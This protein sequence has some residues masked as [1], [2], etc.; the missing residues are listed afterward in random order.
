M[1]LDGCNSVLS[2]GVYGDIV[3]SINIY[4]IIQYN[5]I[6]NFCFSVVCHVCKL[7]KNTIRIGVDNTLL[8][9]V[10]I[11][12]VQQKVN[13]NLQLGVISCIN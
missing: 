8:P 7:Y 11:I 5:T 9:F 12:L 13:R 2:P 4:T 10:P 3:L 1:Q 6:M